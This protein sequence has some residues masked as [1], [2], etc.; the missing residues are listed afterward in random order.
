M[1]WHLVKNTGCCCHKNGWNIS[2]HLFK[3]IWFCCLKQNWKCPGIL[4]NYWV[5]LPETKLEN[6][7][8]KISSFVASKNGWKMSWRFIKKIHACCHIATEKSPSVW[9]NLSDSV[10]PKHSWKT[11]WHLVKNIQQTR[12]K[13]VPTSSQNYGI[14]LPLIPSTSWQE[15]QRQYTWHIRDLQKCKT[16][17]CGDW[18]A[19][20]KVSNRGQRG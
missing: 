1:S 4:P 2:Q 20:C 18:A 6:V 16:L 17:D 12:L 3:N 10:A 5:F 19:G 15:G 14:R 9:V 13:N 7:S 11:S 8:S